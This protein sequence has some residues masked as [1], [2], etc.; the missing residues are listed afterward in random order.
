FFKT[1]LFPMQPS[2]VRAPNVRWGEKKFITA[3][4]SFF[5]LDMAFC[6]VA[7]SFLGLEMTFCTVAMAVCG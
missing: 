4:M 3:A 5:V 6:T 1:I 2:G 7:M